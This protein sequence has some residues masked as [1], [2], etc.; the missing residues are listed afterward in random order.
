M[1][2]WI[3]GMRHFGIGFI[4][5]VVTVYV[6]YIQFEWFNLKPIGTDGF[7]MLQLGL[8]LVAFAFLLKP[9]QLIVLEV[10]E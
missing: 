1:V 7:R 9:L 6:P 4:L 3:K 8:I 2:N 5:I 10:A